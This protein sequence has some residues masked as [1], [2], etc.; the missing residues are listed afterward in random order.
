MADEV[1]HQVVRL[2]RLAKRA[3]VD[4]VVASPLEIAHIRRACG[5]GF[6]IVTPGV[7]ASWGA[8]ARAGKEALRELSRVVLLTARL[9]T[10][11]LAILEVFAKYSYGLTAWRIY[12]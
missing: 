4:G 10:Y 11:G 3:G 5:R 7:R 2:A 9:Q 8:R 6:L 12:R 1:E